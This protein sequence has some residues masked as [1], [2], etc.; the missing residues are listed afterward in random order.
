MRTA[1]FKADKFIDLFSVF[2][3]QLE[4]CIQSPVSL[5]CLESIA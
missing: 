1:H 5:K 4:K 2:L 3:L